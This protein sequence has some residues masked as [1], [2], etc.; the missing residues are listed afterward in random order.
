MLKPGL[1]MEICL[2][3]GVCASWARESAFWVRIVYIIP[4]PKRFRS[5]HRARVDSQP[6]D[7]DL[8]PEEVNTRSPARFCPPL[9][10]DHY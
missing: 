10:I 2:F 5:I 7:S 9:M 6:H 1:V 4:S 3:T 8:D